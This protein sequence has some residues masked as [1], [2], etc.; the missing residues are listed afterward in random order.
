MVKS[1]YDHFG[2]GRQSPGSL[3]PW[4]NIY[5]HVIT[6]RKPAGSVTTTLAVV[7]GSY[8]HVGS[9]R[10]VLRPRCSI[11]DHVITSR[12]PAG[13]VTT[14]LAVVE[15]SY[16]HVGGRRIVLRPRCSI[17]DHVI[18]NRKPAGPITTTLAM[19]EGSYDHVG[20]V[21]GGSTI[22]DMI[23]RCYDHDWP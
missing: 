20:V 2:R 16:D 17:Y 19:V 23:G 4:C 12:K 3:R 15:G 6:S 21:K 9:R 8:D 22:L 18:T 10:V 7:E 5:D 13:P 14:T 1:H 11:Y